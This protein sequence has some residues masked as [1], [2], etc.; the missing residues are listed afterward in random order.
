VST[1]TEPA[2]PSTDQPTLAHPGAPREEAVPPGERVGDFVLLGELGRGGMGVVYK[3]FEP[4]LGRHVA[5]KMILSG[6][7]SSADDLRRFQAEA[8]AAARL[9]HPHIVKVHRV[10]SCDNRHFYSMDFIDGPSLA[11]R[12]APGPL[13]GRVAARYLAVIARAIHHAHEQGILHRDLKPGNILVDKTDQPLVTD[14]GLAKHLSADRGQTRTGALMGTPS[15]MAPEQARGDRE[16]SPAADVYGLGALLYELLTA[17]P[18][19]RG[20]TTLETVKQ[21]LEHDPAPPRLLNPRIDR[22]LET[23]C[24]KCLAKSPR[25]RYASARAL[26]EDLESYLE[27]GPIQARSLNMLDYLSRTLERSQFDV[28]FRGAAGVVLG[29]AAIVA[30]MHVVKHLLI[31]THQPVWSI[32]AAHLV[33]FALMGV[34]LWVGRPRGLLPVTTA[35]RLLWSVWVGYVGSCMMLSEATRRM[36]GV[37][38]LYQGVLYPFYAIVTGMAFFILGSSFWGKL[39]AVA[40]GFF[41]LA[42]VML[43]DLRW[44]TLEFGGAWALAL[45]LVGSRLRRLGREREQT[46]PRDGSS[47]QTEAEHPGENK[48]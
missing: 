12:I 44:A 41:V 29:F 38:I 33:Q 5:V 4:E 8:G 9:Q 46:A 27:G 24:L 48:R 22:D 10:G 20:E 14:F 39:Y 19:F 42:F 17:R 35:E 23:I 40:L 21:V 43:L 34:V 31:R 3:A 16:L 30:S 18:P 26:A 6:A 2:V 45:V 15:Y 25:D 32:I 11:A 13:P 28:E 47:S 7:V 37:E 36:F 1:P